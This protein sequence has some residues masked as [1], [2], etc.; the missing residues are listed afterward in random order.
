MHLHLLDKQRIV[1]ISK[2]GWNLFLQTLLMYL[3]MIFLPIL[4]FLKEKKKKKKKEEVK[5]T[6]EFLFIIGKIRSQVPYL[7]SKDF[8]NFL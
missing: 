4:T 7:M 8:S 2:F 1:V 5:D 3:S 6:N